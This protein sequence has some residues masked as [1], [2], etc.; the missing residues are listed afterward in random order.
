MEVFAYVLLFVYIPL[1]SGTGWTLLNTAV[2][3]W[4]KEDRLT[5][6]RRKER[7]LDLFNRT[8]FGKT[9][10]L[11]RPP[12][13]PDLVSKIVQF[14]TAFF[15]VVKFQA[16]SQ[17]FWGISMA[18]GMLFVLFAERFYMAE[19]PEEVMRREDL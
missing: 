3:G 6:K 15:F 13:W 14:L 1:G 2:R 10:L 17:S 8:L 4:G 12:N 16:A 9:G 19:G 5:K 11:K 18:T 7:T